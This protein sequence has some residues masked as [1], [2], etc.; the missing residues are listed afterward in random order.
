MNYRTLT[1]LLAP[2]HG[3][4][5]A[6]AIARM[7]ME[8]R[9]G[10]SLTELL[11]GK[12]NDL[13]AKENDELEKIAFLLAEGHPVQQV[14]GYAYFCGH[15]FSV[16]PAV[17]IPRPETE[18][19]VAW[20]LEQPAKSY[21]D[22]GT[23][24]GCIAISLALGVPQARVVAVDISPEALEVARGNASQL[25][26]SV[27]FLEADI[28]ALAEQT[29][30]LQVFSPFECI[31]SNPP[32][33]CDSEVSEMTRTVLDYEPHSA[34]FVPDDDPLRFYR[35]IA[36]IAQRHLVSGGRL[37]VETNTAW[38][39]ETAKLFGEEGFVETEVRNDQFGRP[40]MV[41]ALKA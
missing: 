8:E 26:A 25:G 13:S 21:L 39:H 23:G 35:A 22:L 32:Y 36:T 40:R 28:L 30:S 20:A 4:G 14:L 5:E 37:L 18:N 41:G 24:S 9:F 34:L 10:L 33:I 38:A 1:T 11:M 12:D 15:R 19:L 27:T 7:V 31:V 16:S 17:L 6:Q 2:I 3:K 29:D